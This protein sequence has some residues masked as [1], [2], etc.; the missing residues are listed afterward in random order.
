MIA[1]RMLDVETEALMQWAP[2][3]ASLAVAVATASFALWLFRSIG[4]SQ[5]GSSNHYETERRQQMRAHN[6]VYRTFEQR[7]ASL[8]TML[9]PRLDSADNRLTRAIR[10]D[11]QVRRWTSR[12]FL[13]TKIVEGLL[14]GAAVFLLV[15]VT[16]VWQLAVLCG[17]GLALGYPFLCRQ[18]LLRQSDARLQR[19]RVRLPFVIDQIALMMQAG[20]GFE[21]SLRS[22]ASEDPEH[23]LTE[24]LQIV[25]GDITAGRTRRD[26]LGDLKERIP[27]REFGEL[28]FSIIKGEELGT[29]LST[30]LSEQADQMRI[31]RSQWGEKAAAEAE[32]QIVFPGMLV[33]IAC[34]VVV[35]GPIMLPAVNNLFGTGN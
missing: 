17:A 7:I 34:L 1:Q 20:A 12:E 31:K 28:F 33:M 15:S 4:K 30:I 11:P 32:V 2:L 25:L 24:E 29:P 16:G 13:A 6:W 19:Q 23:P 14:V 35:L 8:A 22:I 21:E 26:A 27:D 10:T 3:T 5:V 18:S 9:D